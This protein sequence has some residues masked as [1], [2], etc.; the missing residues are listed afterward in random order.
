MTIFLV[1]VDGVCADFTGA[2]I[3]MIRKCPGYENFE[4]VDGSWHFIPEDTVLTKHLWGNLDARS[5]KPFEGDQE[6]IARL[7]ERGR[8]LFVT[9]PAPRWTWMPERVE[10]L[11]QR[12]N[13]SAKDVIFAHGAEKQF[14]Y[15]DYLIE[16][17]AGN[18]DLWLQHWGLGEGYLIDR[19]Y[20]RK[21]NVGMR[22]SSLL[23]AV[24][25]ICDKM[26]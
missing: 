26:G 3:S 8:V 17:N 22:K 16:D 25:D 9:A 20:N 11:T 23:E 5:L 14:V 1:D 10:W 13:V 12:Y 24:E 6:A 18:L 15:G 21:F 2:A 7:Q 19:S 4:N